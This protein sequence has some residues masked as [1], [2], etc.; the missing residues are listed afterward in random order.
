MVDCLSINQI[1]TLFTRVTKFSATFYKFLGQKIFI[2]LKRREAELLNQ[3][4]EK[5][6]ERSFML[7]DDVLGDEEPVEEEEPYEESFKDGLAGIKYSALNT[8]GYL[9]QH[10]DSEDPESAST[11]QNSPHP[12]S[13]QASNFTTQYRPPLFTNKSTDNFARPKMIFSKLSSMSDIQTDLSR[14][15]SDESGLDQMVLPPAPLPPGSGLS[16][17]S[18]TPTTPTSSNRP[19]QRMHSVPLSRTKMVMTDGGVATSSS[20]SPNGSGIRPSRTPSASSRSKTVRAP[21]PN[22]WKSDTTESDGKPEEDEKH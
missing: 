11:D 18:S 15:A 9:S 8:S 4:K 19:L 22:R 21:I 1:Y 5:E 2:C 10:N 17:S 7:G 3:E 12:S 13:I 16:S 14:S 20:G 6:N